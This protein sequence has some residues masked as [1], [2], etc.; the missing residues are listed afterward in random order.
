MEHPAW[1]RSLE[2]DDATAPIARP[3]QYVVREHAAQQVMTVRRSVRLGMVIGLSCAAAACSPS[4]AS[5]ETEAWQQCNM[6]NGWSK[7]FN[8]SCFDLFLDGTWEVSC[9][10][11]SSPLA[12]TL[13]I[14]PNVWDVSGHP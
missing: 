12:F 2:G 1:P 7:D 10:G 13:E 5:N 4:S 14:S 8:M 6:P 11:G 9:D 3:L